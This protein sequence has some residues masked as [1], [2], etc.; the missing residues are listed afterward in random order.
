MMPLKK[1]E[2]KNPIKTNQTKRPPPKWS[3]CRFKMVCFDISQ[4]FSP[5]LLPK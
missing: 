1:S 4:D 3:L 2:K 5:P